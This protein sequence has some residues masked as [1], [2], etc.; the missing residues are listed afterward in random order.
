MDNSNNNTNMISF[1]K[2]TYESLPEMW[3][4]Q[5]FSGILLGLLAG[6]LREM[7]SW[8]AT[9]GGTATTTANLKDLIFSWRFPLV[10]ILSFALV[11]VFIAIELLAQIN[12][13]NNILSGKPVK[14]KD[15][16]IKGIKSLKLF[17]KPSSIMVLLYILVAVPLGSVGFGISL[18]ESF[19]IPNFIMD[20][21][22]ANPVYTLIFI[23][24]IALL[25]IFGFRSVF[26]LHGM[27]LDHMTVKQAEKQSFK[28]IKEHGKEFV[29]GMLKV[30]IV[31]SL[32]QMVVSGAFELLQFVLDAH[33]SPCPPGYVPTFDNAAM[34]DL[35][36]RILLYRAGCSF[37]VVSGAYFRSVCTLLCGAY[38]MLRFTRYYLAY[39]KGEEPEL[40]PERP[41]KSRY[42]TK[43]LLMTVV[44][45]F[46]L[47]FSLLIGL[48]YDYL[49]TAE[50]PT[51]I[52][53]HRAGGTMASE[54]SLEGLEQAIAH[55]CYASET[56]VQRTA[57][58]YYIINHDDTFY[59]LTGVNKKPE[60][61]TM[62]QIRQL[63]INDTTGNGQQLPVVTI[64]E[65]LDT[66]K[67]REKLFIE[68][69]GPTADQQMADDIVAIVREK[70]CVD[71]VALISLKYDVISYIETTY[72]EFETGTLFFAGIGNFA[73]MN[74]DM[75]LMEE[76]LTD[77]DRI[78]QAHNAD[79]QAI[80]WTVNTE[81]GMNKYMKLGA[82]GII[83]DEVDLAQQVQEKLRNRTE[84]QVLRDALGNIFS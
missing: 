79:K 46:I 69:K 26:I 15:E 14:T 21:I 7:R 59:R 29:F 38:L 77:S 56:D 5:T 41:K 72:P 24:A 22:V 53:A 68:L 45:V 67:G 36:I 13:C 39:S 57:D 47:G 74:C 60:D 48:V 55:N 75:L 8:A 51:N 1:K 63:R 76:E 9:V 42:Y 83:T 78:V 33:G 58:G 52:I 73:T 84:L 12:V 31:T 25:F 66:I 54:N 44:T 18:T 80:V 32:M 62:A 17:M 35:D 10:L 43:M 4:F 37:A 82:D 65:M 49:F 28:M 61:L 71:D 64:E 40:W 23:A 27:L 34:M 6:M 2:L 20:A 11:L 3:S 16:I 50:T 30:I 19:Y 70:D 81:E